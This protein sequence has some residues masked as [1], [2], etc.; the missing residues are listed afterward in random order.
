MKRPAHIAGDWSNGD[1]SG[2]E[3]DF[4]ETFEYLEDPE[5]DID[6]ALRNQ[7][8]H[9]GHQQDSYKAYLLTDYWMGVRHQKLRATGHKC[10]LCG[11][12]ERL[13]VHHKQYPARFT[14]AANLHMLQVLCAECHSKEHH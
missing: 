14:E 8:E 5:E 13:E 4:R 11:C 6:S 10:E 9:F 12:Q 2:L 1:W 7:L 3:M